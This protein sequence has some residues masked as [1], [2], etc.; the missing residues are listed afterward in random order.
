MGQS[1]DVVD[2][3]YE[4]TNARRAQDLPALVADDVTFVGPLMQATGAQEYVAMNEHLLGFHA[5]TRMLRQFESGED[6]CSIYELDMSTPA[7]GSISVT[8]ADWIR[9]ADGKIAS[10]RIYFDPRAFADAFGM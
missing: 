2:R 9:V 7:G 5:D 8:I 1:T 4:A 10:Q 3:F 6:V